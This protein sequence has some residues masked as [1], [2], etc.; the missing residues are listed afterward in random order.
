MKPKNVLILLGA[1][2]AVLV[3][4]EAFANDGTPPFI[5]EL[6]QSNNTNV[7]ISLGFVDSGEPGINDTYRVTRDGP[8]GVETVIGDTTF[9]PADAVETEERCRGG[10]EEIEYCEENPS[11]CLSWRRTNAIN[12]NSICNSWKRSIC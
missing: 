8:E 9:S 7:D 10:W 11:H 5:H 6:I 3:S 4:G 12:E 1:L 2:V